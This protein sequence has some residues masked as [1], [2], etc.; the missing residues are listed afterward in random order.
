[1]T[2]KPS[3]FVPSIHDPDYEKEYLSRPIDHRSLICDRGRPAEKLN[4][5]WNFAVDPYDT[6]LRAK[7]YEE[8]TV[9]EDGRTLPLDYSF[10]QWETIRVPSCWNTERERYFLY[11]GSAVYTRKFQYVPRGEKRVFLKFG[12]ANYEAK[13]F[14]NREYLGYHR[15]GSTPF[16][17]E[18]TGK[19]QRENRI[20]VVV[21]N[22]RKRTRVPCENTDWFNYGGLYRDVELIRLPAAFI[23]DFAVHLVP[24]SQF[25]RIRAAVWIDGADRGTARLTIRELGIDCPIPVENGSGT[26]VIDARPELWSPEHPK[27]YDVR[28]SFGEDEVIDRIGFREI[29][30]DGTDILLNGEK[31]YLKGV[32]AHEESVNN[33]KA[34]TE[35]E[36]RENFRLA[37]E[38]NCN[39]M[40]LAHYPHTEKAARIADE[41]GLMLWEEIPVYWAIDFENEETY[42]DAENQLSELILRDRNRASV[43][44]W[45]VG[46]EN[47]DTDARYRFMSRL[48]Q[49][50][51]ELDPTRPV[52][53]ACMLDHV[54]HVISD[55]LADVLDII[56]ANEYYGW[57][58][59][60]FDNLVKLF[61]N[62]KPDKPVI[63]T[64]FGADAKPGHRG[65]RDEKG[66]EDCQL[67]IYEKQ[68]RVLERI[69][70]VKGMS[71][72]ILYDFRC[73]RRLHF[74]Q[75]FY[76]TKGL[77]SA[78]KTHKKPAFYVMKDFYSR[79]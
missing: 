75:N 47:A 36:I 54:N 55:R 37:K 66:T 9:D 52:S 28:L 5:W 10:D 13:V 67:D 48:V 29:R 71:P 20:L 62:S 15:G 76:N 12:A 31:I 77:L 59:T 43:I 63:V 42:R 64:E 24:G 18:V 53:A 8:K 23:K 2:D 17:V 16:C 79:W 6:C 50:A 35:D 78:D 38:M 58:Q 41:I 61:E 56:G 22:T 60:N 69:S 19:L 21:N 72:W 57:Y 14:L 40:R 68:V 33:G 4:G 7:W 46:N 1:M 65:T 11:E 73:P 45:S 34:V 44:I 39:F 51:R 27:L 26:A 25:S 32:S 49:R 74:T 70:C 30:V 3:N